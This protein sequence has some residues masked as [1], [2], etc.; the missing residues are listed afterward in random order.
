M[1]LVYLSIKAA[2]KYT[3]FCVRNIPDY[4]LRKPYL[5]QKTYIRYKTVKIHVYIRKYKDKL[6]AKYTE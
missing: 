4:D 6:L 2:Y 3:M 1:Y 5:L